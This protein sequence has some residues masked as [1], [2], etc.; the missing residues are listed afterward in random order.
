MDVK[1][2][3]P[4]TNTEPHLDKLGAEENKAVRFGHLKMVNEGLGGQVIRRKGK[5]KGKDGR[6]LRTI[7]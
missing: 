2:V 6:C 1:A 7:L 3:S 5:G 4:H